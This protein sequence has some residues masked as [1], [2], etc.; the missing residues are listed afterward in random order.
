KQEREEIAEQLLDAKEQLAKEKAAAGAFGIDLQARVATSDASLEKMTEQYELIKQELD[1]ITEQSQ[2]TVQKLT[3]ERALTESSL[4]D[5]TEKAEWRRMRNQELESLLVENSSNISRLEQDV[6]SLRAEASIS[7]RGQ[8]L[9]QIDLR[10]L[11]SRYQ[12]VFQQKLRQEQLL[13]ELKSRLQMATL[14]LH[15]MPVSANE[16]TP[17][18]APEVRRKVKKND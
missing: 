14:C 13:T 18:R 15:E 12:D 10:D 9:A 11:Q 4:A 1:K 2:A 8:S 6:K 3:E 16:V 5:V 7:L 17:R